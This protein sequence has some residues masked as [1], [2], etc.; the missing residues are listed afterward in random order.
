VARR[1]ADGRMAER[2][3]E[4]LLAGHR[5]NAAEPI[6]A[7]D[8]HGAFPSLGQ[9]GAGLASD[10]IPPVVIDANVVR[11]DVRYAC[12]KNQRTVLVT[13]ANSGAVRLY[14][15]SHVIGELDEHG[16]EWARESK[17]VSH[18]AFK[19]RWEAEY[20]PLVREVRNEDLGPALLDPAERERVA[21]LAAVDPD[22]V[23]SVILS[24]VLGAFFLSE[25]GRAVR[26][27][28]GQDV[29][30]EAH[31]DWLEV[32]KAGGD[33]GELG[34]SL[35]VAAG[36]PLAG[37][38]GLFSLTRWLA[39]RFSP[40]VPA[41]LGVTLVGLLRSRISSERWQ[42]LGGVLSD[43]TSA[44]AHIQHQHRI[45][46][47]RFRQASPPT[48]AWKELARTNDDRVVLV[49]ACL[50]TLARSPASPMSAVELAEVLPDLGVGRGEKLVR[51]VLRSQG[52]FAEPYAGRW[53]VGRPT[54]TDRCLGSTAKPRSPAN[55]R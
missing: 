14:A 26:A 22:D 41:S 7:P 16:E 29:D 47:E 2:V 33:A 27:V 9:L 25:D 54:P 37:A 48:P 42:S 3:E 23:P 15:A 35:L 1:P 36:V 45:A 24:L 5:Q 38:A 52:C 11:N 34:K 19:A 46:L 49:R 17:G 32:L 44:L 30:L 43:L 8:E 21:Q 10:G 55:R 28:Y 40:W 53:Q 13:A 18:A 12:E 20:R 51:E 6:R 50:R 31:R 4:M 39:Q